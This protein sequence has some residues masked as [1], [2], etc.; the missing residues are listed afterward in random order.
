MASSDWE[1]AQQ[2]LNRTEW[3]TPDN[4]PIT[5][6]ANYTYSKNRLTKIEV[7]YFPSEYKSYT[8]YEYDNTGRISKRIFYNETQPSSF[9]EHYYDDNGNLITEIKKEITDDIP[10]MIV[11]IEYQFDDKNNPYKA[12]QRLLL[13]GVNTNTNNILKK[14]QTLY[15][16]APLAEKIQETTYTYEYNSDGYPIRKNEK[17]TFE[18]LSAN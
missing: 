1:I 18:Y 16:D 13:P 15:F 6:R 9:T 2:S 8:T 3:V 7:T 14:V 11:K 5:C 12:F 10:V 4:T 17:F